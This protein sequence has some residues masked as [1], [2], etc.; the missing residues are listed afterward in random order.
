MGSRKKISHGTGEG[1]LDTLV[2]EKTGLPG[3]PA[4]QWPK[5]EVAAAPMEVGTGKLLCPVGYASTADHGGEAFF[6]VS[7]DNVYGEAEKVRDRVRPPG[8]ALRCVDE[9]HR[10]PSRRLTRGE[11]SW[12]ARRC[13]G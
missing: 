1:A 10:F 2:A 13:H 11:R 5:K 8:D 6:S 12:E 4:E 9:Q 7:P 3:G